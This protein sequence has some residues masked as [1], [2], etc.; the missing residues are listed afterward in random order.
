MSFWPFVYVFL[1][2]G[3]G[4]TCRYVLANWLNKANNFLPYGTFL[5][6][7]FSCIVLGF[8]IGLALKQ[9]I[10]DRVKLLLMTGFCGG[11][12]TFSTFSAELLTMFQEGNMI[13]ATA[14][15]VLSLCICT[16]CLMGAF[17]FAQ[18]LNS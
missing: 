15:V 1:G 3:I 12:S 13:A 16:L 17:I 6:N 11:F 9:G 7:L 2:G 4:S 8:L 18:N 14:Y 10:D 5:A